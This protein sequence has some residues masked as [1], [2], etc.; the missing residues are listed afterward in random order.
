M[1]PLFSLEHA[2]QLDASDTLGTFRAQF[3]MP[4]V[5]GKPA[6]YFTGNSLGLQARRVKTII[7]EELSNWA[8]NGVEGHVKGPRP[9]VRYH[10]FFN[11]AMARLVGALPQEVVLMNGLTTNL[12]LMMVSFYRPQGKRTKI[13]CEGKAFPSDQYALKSQLRFH[14]LDESHLVEILPNEEDE[15]LNEEKILRTIAEQG[16]EIAL[17]MMGGVNY[18]TG[19]KLDMKRITAAAKDKGIVV[20][21]DLAHAAGNVNLALH[22]WGVDFAAWCGYKYLNAGPGGVS[23]VFV[24]EKHHGK[25]DIPRFEGWW[26]HDKESR[27]EMPEVFEPIPTAEA[28][29]LSNAPVFSMAPLLA[30]LQL[31]EEAGFEKLLLKAGRL[32][33]YLYDLIS[34]LAREHD[35]AIKILTPADAAQRG[36]QLSLV[37]P[38]IGKTVFREISAKG[39]IAD[40]R[41]PDVIRVAPVPLYN[42][43]S[44]VYYLAKGLKESLVKHL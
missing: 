31:F 23:G 32:T 37:V 17:L 14:G 10:E 40:W 35:N 22:E 39:V 12:H 7:E 44:D 8:E 1:P 20:G 16:E 26:G 13:L 11:E 19:Q 9:W 21:W 25:K 5:N 2:R 43:F 30:S 29:Q 28:W 24:H 34:Q 42:S 33:Q 6:H 3:L 4:L 27:F 36:C 38:G 15:L 41:E 18:Y